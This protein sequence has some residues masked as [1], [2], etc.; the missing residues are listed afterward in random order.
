MIVWARGVAAGE[1]L[2]P[3][4]HARMLAESAQAIGAVTGAA[5]QL[6]CEDHGAVACD[7]H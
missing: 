2:G 5:R 3:V 6:R 1:A 7:T 4:Q